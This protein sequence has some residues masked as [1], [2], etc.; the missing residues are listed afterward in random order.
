MPLRNLQRQI[1][2]TSI[3]NNVDS[4][5][6]A[7][8]DGKS[9][10]E[11][12]QKRLA[13][14][15]K[16]KLD[17]FDFWFMPVVNPDGYEY[18]HVTDRVWRKTRSK[19]S[20]CTGVDPNR[21]YPHHWSESGVSTFSCSQIYPGP[22]PLSEPET[23]ALAET[24]MNNKHLIKMYISLHAYSQMILTPYGYDRVYP[25]NYEE[26]S[27]VAMAGKNAIQ[28]VRSIQYK[29]GPSSILLYPAAGGSDDF[30]HGNCD[31]R[32]SYTMELPDTGDYGF[33]LPAEHIIP[34]GE[35]T[36]FGLTAMID[37]MKSITK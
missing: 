24:L 33:L 19:S 34:V 8:L 13:K 36:V 4:S 21:N 7:K 27:M 22:K 23:A 9:K 1:T 37:A 18:S 6:Y 30:A 3:E 15:I 20:F 10:I 5:E 17:D 32:F 12:K 25:A 29:Y 14:S 28:S 2:A 31:I 16:E 35:E 26:L 11:N